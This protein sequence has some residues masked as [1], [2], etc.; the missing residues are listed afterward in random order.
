MHWKKF[1][2]NL[3]DIMKDFVSK[4][5]AKKEDLKF[6]GI[7]YDSVVFISPATMLEVAVTV[8]A[9]NVQVE[10]CVP[11]GHGEFDLHKLKTP[12][13]PYMPFMSVVKGA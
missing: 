3:P 13:E 2:A 9:T 4:H 5:V 12:I 6:W 11:D 1:Y 10:V 7:D 8:T